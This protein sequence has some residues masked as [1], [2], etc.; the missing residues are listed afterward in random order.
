MAL[1]PD[2]WY[3]NK[4]IIS[5]FSEIKKECKNPLYVH[6]MKM[7]SGRGGSWDYTGDVLISLYENGIISGIKEEH[8]SL[9]DSYDFV[10]SLDSNLDIIVAGGSMRR[11]QYLRSAGANT[12]L[13]GLGNLFPRIEQQ[14]MKGVN[15]DEALS[16]ETMLFDVFMKY[17]WHKSLRESLRQKGLTC[18]F[19]RM[20]WPKVSAEESEEIKN[21]LSKIEK[22]IKT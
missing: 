7:R 17:G 10:S 12:F 22:E 8:S 20:P 13:S 5:Y 11:H 18:T 15:I 14:Y 2:R 4:T 1:Y 6:C 9:K 21:V 16:A 19:D 3:D